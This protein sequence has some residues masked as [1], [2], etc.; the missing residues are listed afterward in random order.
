MSQ[1]RVLVV[2]D[3]AHHARPDHRRPAVAIPDI[4]V[5]GRPAI[6]MRRAS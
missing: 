5:V 6:R 2:D 4:E 1:I 3:F